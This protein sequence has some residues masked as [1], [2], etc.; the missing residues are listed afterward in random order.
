MDFE[1]ER[2]SKVC[3]ASG[4]ELAPGET[5]YSV[6]VRTT[7]GLKRM[8]YSVE[9]WTSPPAD[10]VASWKSQVP[11]ETHRKPRMA[12]NDVLLELFDELAHTPESAE[13][14]YVLALLMIRRRLFKLE[15]TIAADKKAGVEET[16]VL[17]C[18]RRDETY[19]VPVL[20]PDERRMN[21]LQAQLQTLLFADAPAVKPAE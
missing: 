8:D 7:E 1:V 13:L 14:R 2:P 4:R 21:E 16:L 9:A 20:M 19:R 11:I 17:H 10:A 3:A 5:F 12:P 15:E 6:L 18:A